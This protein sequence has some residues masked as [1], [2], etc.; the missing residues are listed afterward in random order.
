MTHQ[1]P[2]TWW[3]IKLVKLFML[4]YFYHMLCF[5]VSLKITVCEF[6]FLHFVYIY[7]FF[8]KEGRLPWFVLLR[9]LTN[10]FCSVHIFSYFLLLIHWQW[11][12]MINMQILYN[13]LE[14]FVC[15]A[16]T[17]KC[18]NICCFNLHLLWDMVLICVFYPV[19]MGYHSM[20][21]GK[22]IVAYSCAYV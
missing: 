1:K 19:E 15:L 10:L 21:I 22:M 14:I 4:L 17:L 12:P 13:K 9:F 2:F 7:I 11:A 6:S 5:C 16:I 3:T 8:L 20:W 18:L